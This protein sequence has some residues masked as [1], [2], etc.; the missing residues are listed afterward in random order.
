MPFDPPPACGSR[1][2]ALVDRVTA[3]SQTGLPL[4]Q[5]V[6]GERGIS[7]CTVLGPMPAASLEGGSCQR[8]ASPVPTFGL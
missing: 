6:L 2:S 4:H 8:N 7:W 5:V 1:P 3:C